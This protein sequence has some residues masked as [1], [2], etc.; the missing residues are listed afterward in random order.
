MVTKKKGRRSTVYRLLK[1]ENFQ[2]AIRD[3]YLSSGRFTAKE[4]KIEGRE[5]YVVT[6]AMVKDKADWCVT[7]ENITGVTTSIEG[8]TPAAVVLIRLSSSDNE[9]ND[10]AVYAL[11]YG[12]GFQL[13]NATKI[14]H[15]FGQRI[16]VRTADP[17]NLRSLTVSSM[18]LRAKISRATI[19]G[20]DRLLGFGVGDVG[21]AVS[22]IVA[23][24]NIPD[25]SCGDDGNL[26][27]RGADALNIPLGADPSD[28][29]SDLEII[30]KTLSNEPSEELKALEQLA[31]VK[32]K[33]TQAKLEQA[34]VESFGTGQG[35]IGIAWPYERIDENG[36]PDSWV[37]YDLVL[38][39]P[40]VVTA[41]LPDW[42]TI[43]DWLGNVP[44][45]DRLKRIK[46]ASIQVCRDTEGT[47]PISQKIPLKRW[48]A[49]EI[50]L[51][52]VR[53]SLFDGAWY[54]IHADYLIH[55][56]Q[57]A[58]KILKNSPKDISFPS[59]SS[60]ESEQVYNVQL[61]K[62]LN[63][64]CLDRD[65][66]RTGVHPR[67]IEP[68]DVYL[69]DGTLIHVK[70]V[71]SSAQA[72]HL[73]AQALVSTESLC[74]DDVARKAME[75]K[76]KDKGGEIDVNMWRPRRVVLA[77]HRRQDKL[78]DPDDL[79]TFS[80]VNLIKQAD[81]LE[82]RGVKVEVAVIAGN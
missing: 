77:M 47:E 34:L 45:S 37:A 48:L 12:M 21:E 82:S 40:K 79:F 51:E 26:Q 67:G 24:A 52:N 18:D 33:E 60:A 56:K 6:G 74:F 76:I 7:V 75:E 59:W 46:R 78:V 14:D 28:V 80:K 30:E 32:E 17:E 44:T 49:F 38:R 10:D 66:I 62:K 64:F 22:R 15:F 29:I 31:P 54:K 11:S 42:E 25:L 1:V 19:P 35:T 43:K 4:F 3:K 39:R 16:A 68:C 53:Y 71:E 13:L 70:R 50:D 58:A 8:K 9:N 61:A 23:M 69:D 20:G 65:L 63:G 81:S 2:D 73:F 72:S 41:G 57:K 5:G 55:I 36:T 27:L